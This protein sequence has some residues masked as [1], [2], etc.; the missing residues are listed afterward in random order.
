M[1]NYSLHITVLVICKI[2][3]KN[4]LYTHC[5]PAF[6]SSGCRNLRSFPYFSMFWFQKGRSA[7]YFSWEWTTLL[8]YAPVSH[9][10]CKEK[11]IFSLPSFWGTAGKHRRLQPGWQPLPHS[12]V[13][14]VKS[15][16]VMDCCDL[17][18][19]PGTPGGEPQCLE[20]AGKSAVC[21]SGTLIH[22]KAQ[23]LGV[24][25]G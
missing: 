18:S 11:Q 20:V 19:A 7:G 25:V 15:T 6:Y 12:W 5:L 10:E 14:C 3:H 1:L 21:R 2:L 23:G 13:H 16:A 17:V 8:I 4:S 22:R 24:Y 9:C